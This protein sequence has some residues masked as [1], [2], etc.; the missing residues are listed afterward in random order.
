MFL[1]L[2][3]LSATVPCRASD[4][5][6]PGEVALDGQGTVPLAGHGRRT[7][8]LDSVELYGVA[9]YVEGSLD[10]ARLSLPDVVKVLRIDVRYTEDLRRP[11]QFDWRRELVPTVDAA[12]TAH[13]RGAFAPLQRGDVVQIEFVPGKGTTVRVNRAVAVSGAN[14]DLMLAFLDHWIGQRPVSEDVKRALL[15]A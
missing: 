10:R 2:V 15:G 8:L 6:P 4:A 7:H 9:V 5:Q 1:V 3:M 11:I 14:H 12:G 13:L